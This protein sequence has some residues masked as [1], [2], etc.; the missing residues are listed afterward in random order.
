MTT[1]ILIVGSGGR[2]DAIAQTLKS[3]NSN[4]ELVCAPGNGGMMEIA[5]C[6]PVKADDSAGLLALAKEIKPNLTV[7]GPEAPLVAGITDLFYASR[8]MVVGPRKAAAQLEGSK[9]F[10]KQFM[11]RHHIPTADAWHFTHPNDAASFILAHENQPL[12]IKAD[13]LCGG[14]GVTVAENGKEALAAMRDLMVAKKFGSA[15]N[16]VVIEKKLT[17]WECSLIVLS[18]G[19]NVVPFLPATDYKRRNDRNQGVNTGGMGCYS[20]VPAFTPALKDEVMKK[21]VTPT[22]NWIGDEGM[23]FRGFLYFGLMIT[24]QGPYVLEYNVRMGDPEASVILPLLKSNFS[25]LLLASA[26]PSGLRGVKADWRGEDVAVGVVA[27]AESYPDKSSSDEVITGIRQAR[28]LGALVYHAG[29]ARNMASEV[30]TAGGRILDV[31]GIGKNFRDA[32]ELAYT[33]MERINFKGKDCRTDIASQ[34][35]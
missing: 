28:E 27:V 13:G 34:L 35:S 18:D 17:G 33:G 22:V 7:V 6:F 19:V 23:P 26:V 5:K 10:A 16:T 15:G 4:V 21:I 9:W 3:T 2:E 24:D 11:K 32:R 30:V 12:V 14:K 25:Q 8:F 1:K 20:P 29:T 31:V